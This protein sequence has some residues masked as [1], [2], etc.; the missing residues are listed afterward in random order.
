MPLL[1]KNPGQEDGEVVDTAVRTTDVLPT[2]A[3]ELGLRLSGPVDGVP[4]DERDADP[5]TEIDVPDSWELGTTTT[6]GEFL[7]Q[8][9]ERRRYERSLLE[10]AGY[11]ALAM[12]PRPELVGRRVEDVAAG[13][14]RARLDDPGAYEDVDP[15]L[16]PVWVSGT[17]TVPGA[18]ELAI[19][20]NGR[21]AATTQVDR[22]RF[23]ALVP[24][25]VLRAGANEVEIL[26]ID[27]DTFRKL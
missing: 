9:E 19:A 6:F 21:I 25:R 5:S 13:D 17:T 15:A 26:E 4:A 23:G 1:I 11:D 22:R 18:S 24:P 7:R 10:P 3:R 27:G 16:P 2:I 12:G 14:G 20:V 8:R